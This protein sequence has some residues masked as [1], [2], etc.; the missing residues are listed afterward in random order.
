MII[1]S[2]T[3]PKERGQFNA[4]CFMVRAIS[5]DKKTVRKN[6]QEFIIRPEQIFKIKH[7]GETDGGL[8]YL[9]IMKRPEGQYV[10]NN[11]RLVTMGYGTSRSDNLEGFEIPVDVKK[12][13]ITYVGNIM[14]NEYAE[15]GEK[16][17][18]LNNTYERDIKLAQ[19]LQPYVIW[20]MAINNLDRKVIYK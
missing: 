17:I 1:S 18:S 6:S 15:V 13:E 11:V 12:G 3:F 14:F 9:F 20:K 16:I 2:V 19:L 10:I 5:D 8:T 7:Q 4:Y